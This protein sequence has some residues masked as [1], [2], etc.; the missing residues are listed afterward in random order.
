MEKN[1]SGPMMNLLKKKGPT[2]YKLMI[3]G[4]ALFS[5]TFEAVR[6]ARASF[7]I[8]EATTYLFYIPTNF[9]TMFTFGTG[10]NHFL[11]TLLTKCASL[12][13]GQS[14]LVLRLP[15]L[16]GYGVYLF[17]AFL[18]LDRFVKNKV[19]VVCG[20]LLL[21]INPYVIDFFSL[22]RGYG[23]SLGFL[24]ASLFF[25]FSFLNKTL[26]HRPDG[27]RHLQYSLIAAGL[28]VLSS[29]VLLYVYLSLV[30]L[31]LIFF[32]SWNHR[33][34][35][36]LLV[37][38]V[39]RRP[40]KKKALWLGM[41]AA[42]VLFNILVIS[43]DLNLIQ[44]LFE[45]VTVQI[46]GLNEEDK[47]NMDVFRLDIENQERRLAYQGDLW[48]LDEPAYFTAIKFRCP[49]RLLD[50]VKNIEIVIG[51]KT[52]AVESSEIKRSKAGPQKNIAVF[53]SPG[54]VSLK[55]SFMPTFRSVIN[56]RGDGF[57]LKSILPRILLVLGIAVLIILLTAGGGRL[58][59]RWKIFLAEQFR[60]LAT[61]SLMLAAFVGYPLYILKRSGEFNYGGQ[62]GFIHDTLLSLIYK[63]FYGKTYFPRQ[64]HVVFLLIC[65]SVL[66]FFTVFFIQAR[67]RAL[68]NFLPGLSLLTIL[69]LISVSSIL[70]RALF[71]AAYL[72][73]RTA[74]FLI[75]MFMLFL[76]FIFQDVGR[77]NRSLNIISVPLLVLVTILSLY[78]FS[79]TANTT[80]ALDW[81]SDAD[82]K[83]VL[84]DLPGLKE[85]NFS[86]RA[87]IR[88]GV[89]AGFNPS[90]QYYLKRL[91]P[92]WLEV[93]PAPPYEG[94]DFYYFDENFDTSRM[95]SPRLV[96]IKR[97]PISGDV[98]MKP[99]DE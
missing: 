74:L 61:T 85:A 28:A 49:V 99:E 14:E 92:A 33:D 88:L 82:T 25:F 11:N 86:D 67:K 94:F 97:Y 65:L 18:I 48:K 54:S 52:Y 47:Q 57:Y 64:E 95:T 73:Q 40:K 19:I 20:Y 31:S 44:K 84:H 3:L 2:F 34:N 6:A 46:T 4:I 35:S 56:W 98:L 36:T 41:A 76:I 45:P 87:R 43:Q 39:E 38:S 58:L 23:L 13:A 60:P 96:L 75:P 71:N 7:T 21:C 27:P 12:L 50:K 83:S 29:F 37:P 59:R 66:C 69:L 42:A 5:L 90:F 77:L 53:A 22:C 8:D 30:L 89:A 91:K 17:F 9:L 93:R 51:R 68:T 72:F 80:M 15:N 10:N 24:M 79:Q 55:H 26:L 16:L 62:T 63:S 78:H 1:I 32:V 81:R 70:L